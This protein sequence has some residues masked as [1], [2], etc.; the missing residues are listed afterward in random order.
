MEV[1]NSFESGQLHK[2]PG[3]GTAWVNTTSLKCPV[4]IFA[5]HFFQHQRF[6]P[7]LFSSPPFFY[8][9]YFPLSPLLAFIFHSWFPFFLPFVHSSLAVFMPFFLSPIIFFL[10]F[11]Y[12]LSRFSTFL[13]F[14]LISP[15][16][17]LPFFS[18]YP[19][20]YPLSCESFLSFPS[21][22]ISSFPLFPLSVPVL[23]CLLLSAFLL[24]SLFFVL[25][26]LQCYLHLVFSSLNFSANALPF[27][28]SFSFL[29]LFFFA[30]FLS[31]LSFF[32]SSFLPSFLSSFLFSFCPFYPLNFL[33]KTLF[34]TF[35]PVFLLNP[36]PHTSPVV[37]I[38]CSQYVGN[39]ILFE[40]VNHLNWYLLA[41]YLMYKSYH[42]S[43]SRCWGGGVDTT[44]KPHATNLLSFQILPPVNSKTVQMMWY[45]V[46]HQYFFRWNDS[47]IFK[48]RIPP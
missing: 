15:S 2:I 16:F 4:L 17:F 18:L 24:H 46:G 11:I 47:G 41:W 48:P 6:L 22:C 44:K 32:L 39:W 40:T 42:M 23:S 25:S 43:F 21:F 29:L 1:E 28:S 34:Y 8:F 19:R 12:S 30:S 10:P 9:A 36:S 13:S 38:N 35:C 7:F 5:K 37:P 20:Y 26:S 14:F 33:T 27:L 31:S 45:S 3:H